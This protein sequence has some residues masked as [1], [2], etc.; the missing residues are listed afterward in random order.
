MSEAD[1]TRSGGKVRRRLPP[2]PPDQQ[3]SAVIAGM[4]RG[5][6]R[7]RGALSAGGE[8]RRGPLLPRAASVDGS[9]LPITKT[10]AGSGSHNATD[11]LLLSG[12][13]R[14]RYHQVFSVSFLFS[15]FLIVL[16]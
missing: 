13:T 15:L 3:D 11:P 12:M 9:G 5:R 4:R 14:S 6:D 10:S 16:H 7:S 1:S 8:R 2:V